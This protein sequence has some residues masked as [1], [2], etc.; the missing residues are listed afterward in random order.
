M[1]GRLGILCLLLGACA[2]APPVRHPQLE[3]AMPPA[4]LEGEGGAPGGAP[5][6]TSGWSGLAG[7]AVSALVE[8]ALTHNYDLQ[9]AAAR[10]TMAAAQARI[11]GAPARP[12]ASVGGSGSRAR[13]N[14]VGF[15]IPGSGGQVLSTTTTTYGVSLNASWEVDLWGRLRDGERAA[16]ADAAAAQADLLGAQLSLTAQV[17]RTYYGAVEARRQLELARATT[18]NYRLSLKQVEQRYDRGLR[19]ALDVHLAR[20]NLAAAE[21]V[22]A[23]RRLLQDRVGRQLE[24]LLGRYPAGDMP[25]GSELPQI[26][27]PVPAGLPAEILSRRP[28]LVAAERRLAAAGARVRE[29]R[30]ALYPRLSLTGSSGRSSQELGDLLDGDY[31]VWNLMANLSAPLLQGGRLRAGVDLAAA[32][33]EGALT[34]YGRSVLQALA[35]V[36]GLLAAED[37]L[38]QQE[39]AT[40]RAAHEAV[41]ARALARDRYGRGLADSITLLEAQRRAFEAESQALAVRRQRLDA[42]IDLHLALGGG[43]DAQA[44]GAAVTDPEEEG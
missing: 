2:A 43:F 11:A 25:P 33:Q 17:L 8:E 15:P 23:Q 14:F 6:S 7:G 22:V 38:A 26:D 24:V 20:A 4:W 40:V 12:Q 16:L 39:R 42:R 41:A 35:E 3:V 37:F 31:S 29:A 44:S 19:P 28:D 34:Q 9:S 30:K 32:G 5:A 36:E 13:R 27:V 18:D 21:A 1:R 10:V